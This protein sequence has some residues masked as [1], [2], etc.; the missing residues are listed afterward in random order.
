MPGLGIACVPHLQKLL[1]LPAPNRRAG[2]ERAAAR[3]MERGGVT[4]MAGSQLDTAPCRQARGMQAGSGLPC[5]G[6]ARWSSASCLL[7][8]PLR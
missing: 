1:W 4:S 8:F 5:P 6:P 2:A 7:R 3:R